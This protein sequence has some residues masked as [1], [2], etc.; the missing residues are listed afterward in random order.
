MWRTK[1]P[2][3]R[4]RPTAKFPFTEIWAPET[5]EPGR[6]KEIENYNGREMR[7]WKNKSI[8]WGKW[9]KFSTDQIR[10][11]WNEIN[12]IGTR[13]RWLKFHL[14]GILRVPST[15]NLSSWTSEPRTNEIANKLRRRN[16]R[17]FRR[18]R[19][20]EKKKNLMRNFEIGN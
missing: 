11:A 18:W 17:K 2:S 14:R 16:K 10:S 5:F 4:M 12:L 6:G 19:E 9:G 1:V 20:K 15:W 7:K 3:D 13:G 8:H